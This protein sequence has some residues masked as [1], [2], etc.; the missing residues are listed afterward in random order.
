[1]SDPTQTAAQPAS[2]P[3]VVVVHSRRIACDGVGGALGWILHRDPDTY[4]YIPASLRNYPGAAGVVDLLKSAGFRTATSHPVLG[5]LMTI[6]H[7]RK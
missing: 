3:E 5:G 2:S 1:M 4:R 7:A 6:H